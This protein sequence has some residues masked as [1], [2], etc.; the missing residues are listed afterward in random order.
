MPSTWGWTD[1]T[2]KKQAVLPAT[3]KGKAI[4]VDSAVK[5]R[6]DARR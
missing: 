1:G 5:K 4:S 6:Q 3:A 2:V